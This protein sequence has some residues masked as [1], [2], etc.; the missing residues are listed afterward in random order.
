MYRVRNRKPDHS[1]Y[2][3]NNA[4]LDNPGLSLLGVKTDKGLTISSVNIPVM[5]SQ[6][7]FLWLRE[8][9]WRPFKK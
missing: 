3:M 1:G 2:G 6:V 7:G 9:G 8:T 4:K 5:L